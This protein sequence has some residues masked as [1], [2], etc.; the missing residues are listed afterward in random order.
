MSETE[1]RLTMPI[2]SYL[3]CQEWCEVQGFDPIIIHEVNQ[4]NP[5]GVVESATFLF[6]F[7]DPNH[8]LMFKLT[9]AGQ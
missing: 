6:S 5:D 3:D 7:E 9:W 1:V 4:Y 2:Q 8:A